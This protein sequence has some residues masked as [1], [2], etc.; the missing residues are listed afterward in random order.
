MQ[1]QWCNGTVGTVIVHVEHWNTSLAPLYALWRYQGGV[2]D[3]LNLRDF[4]EKQNW[5]DDWG[6]AQSFSQT[7]TGRSHFPSACSYGAIWSQ[8]IEPPAN[9]ASQTGLSRRWWSPRNCNNATLVLTISLTTAERTDCVIFPWCCQMCQRE[10][11]LA[12]LLPVSQAG[13]AQASV[14]IQ[15]FICSSA[16]GGTDCLGQRWVTTSSFCSHT[17]KLLV[18]LRRLSAHVF[19]MEPK[20]P[21][22]ERLRL[23]I[24]SLN[25]AKNDVC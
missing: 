21:E 5:A 22:D 15:A 19:V 20:T 3:I 10:P 14:S 1:L 24:L 8:F 9:H 25:S 16:S 11:E 17:D 6:T 12:L 18:S 23:N 13:F 2:W 4:S 7:V